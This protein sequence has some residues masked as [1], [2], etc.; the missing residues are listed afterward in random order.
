MVPGSVLPVRLGTDPAT[1]RGNSVRRD[2][3]SDP[4]V[5]RRPLPPRP[6][7][8]GMRTGGGAL[9]GGKAVVS[10]PRG[11]DRC[12]GSWGTAIGLLG[13]KPDH[14]DLDQRSAA[15]SMTHHSCHGSPNLGS[16][17]ATGC[18]TG[19][20]LV[21]RFGPSDTMIPAAQ[22]VA[23]VAGGANGEPG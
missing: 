23:M 3:L 22:L 1:A 13:G 20:E 7:P 2:R 5:M 19:T 10:A 14:S 9:L 15:S 21:L 8:P 11:R 12:S 17:A 4:R 16:G 18:L 6:P